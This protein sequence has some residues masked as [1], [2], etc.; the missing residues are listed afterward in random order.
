MKNPPALFVP[1]IFL[2][3]LAE[4]SFSQAMNRGSCSEVIEHGRTGF[5]VS[6]VNEGVKAL[7]ELASID[8]AACRE[9]VQQNFSIDSM[10]D[11]YE[12]VYDAIFDVESRRRA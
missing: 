10:V 11:A 8:S 12:R 4:G 3:R 6:T 2:G 9:R 7:Q 5:L 1:N